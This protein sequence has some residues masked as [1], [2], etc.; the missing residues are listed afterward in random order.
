V[1]R[2]APPVESAIAIGVGAALDRETI[3]SL[4]GDRRRA[5]RNL[6]IT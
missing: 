1:D 3:D 5:R 4:R 2:R 6:W